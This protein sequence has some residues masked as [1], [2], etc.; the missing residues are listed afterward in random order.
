MDKTVRISLRAKTFWKGMN[1][2]VFTP[3]VSRIVGQ[4]GFFSFG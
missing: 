4:T 1:P 2:S 3:V